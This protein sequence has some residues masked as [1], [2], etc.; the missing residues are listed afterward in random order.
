MREQCENISLY[1]SVMQ[2]LVQNS[3]GL[4]KEGFWALKRDLSHIVSTGPCF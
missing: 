1:V 2:Y 3:N 4:S